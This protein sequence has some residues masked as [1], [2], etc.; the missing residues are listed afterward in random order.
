[1]SATLSQDFTT[2]KRITSNSGLY[3][4]HDRTAGRGNKLDFRVSGKTVKPPLLPFIQSSAQIPI[5]SPRQPF[6]QSV[7]S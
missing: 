2:G 1:M 7:P 6:F 4:S 3:L 5:P